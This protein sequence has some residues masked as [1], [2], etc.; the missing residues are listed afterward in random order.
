MAHELRFYRNLVNISDLHKPTSRIGKTKKSDETRS[1]CTGF[2]KRSKTRLHRLLERINHPRSP[3]FITLTYQRFDG[4]W[5]ETKSHLAKFYKRL[6]RLDSKLS[7]IWRL[8]F[9]ARGT[10]H[11]HL[12]LWP[13]SDE[14]ERDFLASQV[15]STAWCESTNQTTRAAKTYAC[16]V[17]TPRSNEAVF[18]YLVGHHLKEDQIRQDLSSGRY[19]GVVGRDYLLGLD[20]IRT[21]RVSDSV[22]DAF[23]RLCVKYLERVPNK[24]RGV[25]KRALRLI[26]RDGLSEVYIPFHEQARMLKAAEQIAGSNE[27]F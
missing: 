5:K 13:S 19:W 12:V 4:D 15:V 24:G 17:T 10:P 8:E 21:V 2:S 26:I 9:Q 20:P 16:E 27:P 1:E 7:S 22:A 11:Y 14:T 25:S 6:R 3:I 23:R 18:R